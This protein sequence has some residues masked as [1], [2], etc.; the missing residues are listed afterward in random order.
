[1]T[2][3]RR[4]FALLLAMTPGMGGR[5]VTRVLARNEL[6][7]RSP[8]EFLALSP[9]AYREEYRLSKR[10]AENLARDRSG[11]IKSTLET[12]QRLNGLGVSL[13]TSADAHY[14][15]L[16]EEMDPDPPGVLFLYGNARLLESRTF[17]VLSSR[18]ARPADLE[19]IERLTEEAV[20]EGEVLVTSHDKLEYQRSAVV[21]LRWGSP[22]IL[23]LDRGLFQVLGPDL[24]DEAFRA[25]RLWRYEF[26]PSTDLVVSPFRP[27]SSFIG[28]NNQ[29]RDRLVACLSRRLDFVHIAEGGNME[30]LARMALRAE[31]KVRVS[32][33][34]IGYRELRGLGAEVIKT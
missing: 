33:R 5:S 25:A 9:E 18:N 24:R 3:P 12:E 32:D 19:M 30:K 26:D 15:T 6:L 21:P 4:T 2:L 27:D 20:L 34:I 10:A 11:L 17:C 29:V 14:P 16:V 28:V 1:M 22:R 31:R 13:V 23:C 8:E 7:G